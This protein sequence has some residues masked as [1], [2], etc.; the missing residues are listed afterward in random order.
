[1]AA[2][3]AAMFDVAR[4]LRE[5]RE[6]RGIP[7]EQVALTLAMSAENWRHYESGRNQLAVTMLPTLAD[8]YGMT[9]AE[10]VSALLTARTDSDTMY[11]SH[12]E[13]DINSTA[14]YI[15]TDGRRVEAR[16]TRS[17]EYVGTRGVRLSHVATDR[18]LSHAVAQV[19]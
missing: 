14:N 17:V 12:G 19:G 18:P 4:K 5:L 8:L 2:K 16:V 15:Y 7:K 10:L 13:S 11:N 6:S 9:V 1:M 3:T